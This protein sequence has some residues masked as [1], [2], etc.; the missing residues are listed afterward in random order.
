MRRPFIP[1]P[2]TDLFFLFLLLVASTPALSLCPE[3]P[4]GPELMNLF[5]ASGEVTAVQ[6]IKIEVEAP[7]I[8]AWRFR[9]AASLKPAEAST[10]IQIS[11]FTKPD[12]VG[13]ASPKFNDRFLAFLP[14]EHSDLP[15]ALKESFLLPENGSS[16]ICIYRSSIY[17]EDF[18]KRSS[19][20]P[21]VRDGICKIQLTN[22]E[23]NLLIKDAF[24]FRCENQNLE[25]KRLLLLANAYASAKRYGNAVNAL[26]L[27]NG[28][29]NAS[30]LSIAL[31][32]ANEWGAKDDLAAKRFVDRIMTSNLRRHMEQT[33]Q[34]LAITD[35]L[36]DK[37]RFTRLR[38]SEWF[39]PLTVKWLAN[40]F[41][42]SPKTQ[43]SPK[44]IP[45]KLRKT[46]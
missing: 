46:P 19:G 32:W 34:L 30:T 23:A 35:I 36:N 4:T 21:A 41:P 15:L 42:A 37:V 14:K 27:S 9:I 43:L 26:E 1:N 12:Q 8:N 45:L 5:S 28:T 2:G 16:T 29:L 22:L 31:D 20:I 11:F 7:T 17:L 25:K 24:S 33:K 44:K 3:T 18:L 38:S 10:G 13:S 39:I 6:F 40:D